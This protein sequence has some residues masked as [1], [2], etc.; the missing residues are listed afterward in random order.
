MKSRFEIA[1]QYTHGC[2]WSAPGH[3]LAKKNGAQLVWRPGRKSWG[4]IGHRSYAPPDLQIL[5]TRGYDSC[6]D[7]TNNHRAYLDA[8]D[9][10]CERLCAATILRHKGVIDQHFGE[11][12]AERIAQLKHTE[13]F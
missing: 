11:G 4:G 1:S 7:V 2:D 9:Y 6:F 3:I 12:A 10:K 5:G 13:I 8:K